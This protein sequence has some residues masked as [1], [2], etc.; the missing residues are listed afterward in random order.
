MMIMAKLVLNN[1]V[2]N[3][4]ASA[5]LGMAQA[6]RELAAQGVDVAML[7][8]GEPD[9]AT[10]QII[11]DVAKHS[12]DQGHTHYVPVR[13]T[14]SMISAM[15]E[16]FLRDQKVCYAADEVMCTVGGKSAIWLALQ[17]L[18]NEGDE[19]IIC[20]PFWVSYKEQ[21]RLAGGV[22]IVINCKAEHDFMPSGAE[23][24]SAISKKTKA[25]ILN[26]PNNP[27]GGVISRAQLESIAQ[28]LHG[29][30]IFLISDEIYEKLLFDN[31]EHISPA[32]LNADMRERTIVISGV[33]K[34]YAMTGWRVGVVASVKPVICAM[35]KLQGQDTTCLPE[36]IQDAA[37]FALREN[38]AVK[39]VIG[40]MLDA[41]VKRREF[42]LLLFSS[43][44]K[45]NVFKPKGAF[46]LWVDFSA[47]MGTAIKGKKILDDIDFATRML[48]EAHVS[49]V[50]GTP[51][52]A[53][54]FVRFS[55][56]SAQS[57]IEEAYHRINA[58]LQ[59]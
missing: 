27:S 51:F 28:V 39:A 29:T 5:T 8:T 11:C 34:A 58:W 21:I 18:I 1:R 6:A 23:I 57:T 33:A 17:T 20:A 59:S 22:P 43:W 10:A 54:G 14:K 32:S 36:F 19:V 2:K 42:G 53:P 16:K 3:M 44:P 52:G 40:H 24:S 4:E 7:S 48:K 37:A 31:N 12:L 55:I 25:I 30:D 38:D 45:V 13:G 56:A 15:Q 50:P 49:S 47:Y 41:Y 46:Y 9:F 26:S 35:E